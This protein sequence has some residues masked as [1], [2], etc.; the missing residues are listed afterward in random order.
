M[1]DYPLNF[2]GILKQNISGRSLTTYG[3]GGILSSLFEPRT[4]EEAKSLF[5]FLKQEGV[6]Y[7]LIGNG[8]NLVLPDAGIDDFVVVRLS[9]KE[10]KTQVKIGTDNFDLSTFPIEDFSIGDKIRLLVPAGVS[11][12]NLSRQ[13][14]ELGLSGLEYT[15]GIPGTLGGAVK[16]NAGAH[17]ADISSVL[18]CIS[19]WEGS[20]GCESFRVKGENLDFS[21]RHSSLSESEVVLSAELTLTVTDKAEVKEKRGSALR[22]RKETQPL[23]MPSAGSVFRNPSS[24]LPA[25]KIL[26]DLGCKGMRLGGV[27]VSELHSNW[28]VRVSEDA[29]ASDVRGLV[30][31]LKAKVDSD[32]GIILKEEIIFW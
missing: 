24:E 12:M 16:M 9:L 15:A 23:T 29:L 22:Y 21:Y 18:D 14:S 1:I 20:V 6:K 19:V 27:M 31:R 11:M 4:I 10:N 30:D 3:I 28:I 32:L 25:A 26:D 8:S 7:K 2:Q 13:V 17:G 5:L